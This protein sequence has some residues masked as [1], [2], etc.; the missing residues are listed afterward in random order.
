MREFA[1]GTVPNQGGLLSEVLE[2]EF[3]HI[4]LLKLIVRLRIWRIVPREYLEFAQF[5]RLQSTDRPSLEL[6]YPV[7]ITTS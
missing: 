1:L 3:A 7:R 6:C 2:A 4:E 5:H